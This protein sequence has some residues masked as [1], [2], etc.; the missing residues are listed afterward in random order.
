MGTTLDRA[1]EARK[2]V[3]KDGILI[4]GRYGDRSNPAV[5]IERDARTSAVRCLRELGLDLETP[6]TSRPPTRWRS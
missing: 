5:S 3:A 2:L 4:D 6:V 1:E